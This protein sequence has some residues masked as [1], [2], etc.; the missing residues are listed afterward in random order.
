MINKKPLSPLPRQG[1]SLASFVSWRSVLGKMARGL[2]PSLTGGVW[3]WVFFCLFFSSCYSPPQHIILDTPDTDS[4]A[5]RLSRPYGIGYNLQVHA[6]SLLLVEDRPMHWSEG[7]AESSDSI[8]LRKHNELVIAAMT[9]IPED[10]VDSVWIKVAR[11]QET[12]GWLHES[13][14][15]E[16]TTPDDPIS[17]FIHFFSSSHVLWFLVVMAVAAAIALAH[18][19]RRQRFRMILLDDIPSIYPTLLTVTLTVAAWLYALIQDAYP[20]MWVYFYFHP[21]LT[22]FSQPFLLCAFL[23]SVWALFLLSLAVIDDV[24]KQLSTGPAILYMLALLAVCMVDYLVIS[25]TPLV[26]AALLAL[27]YIV[28]ALYRYIRFARPRYLCGRCH[29]KLRNKGRCPRCGAMND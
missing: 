18:V 15:L 8:W 7:V 14:L 23:C 28:F 29:A 26:L 13:D 2:H 10:S 1:E 12:M 16:A 4:T 5:Q 6:D 21:T 19:L 9:T 22:P 20:Q 25:L 24:L 3:G 11:D 17:K 27:A